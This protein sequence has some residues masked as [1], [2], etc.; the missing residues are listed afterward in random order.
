MTKI[1]GIIDKLRKRVIIKLPVVYST[2]PA[3]MIDFVVDTGAMVTSLGFVDASKL[4]GLDLDKLPK[5]NK[6]LLGVGG[7]T[8]TRVLEGQILILTPSGDLLT[9]FSEILTTIP[10]VRYKGKKIDLNDP[11]VYQQLASNFPSLLGM[12]IISQ[13]KLYI[14]FEGNEAYFE[15]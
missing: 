2:N 12:D 14:D 4:S 7:N 10:Q 3:R 15:V 9:K 1:K 5:Y 8:D 13:G 11:R 6:P